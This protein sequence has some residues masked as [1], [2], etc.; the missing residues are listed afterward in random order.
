MEIISK[1]GEALQNKNGYNV[2]LYNKYN[3]MAMEEMLGFC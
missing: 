3:N 2:S 1:K